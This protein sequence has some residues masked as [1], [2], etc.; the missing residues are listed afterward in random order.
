M[1]GNMQLNN[2]SSLRLIRACRNIPVQPA[3]AIMLHSATLQY[4]LRKCRCSPPPNAEVSIPAL[5]LKMNCQ[6]SGPR[7]MELA[8]EHLL[9]RCTASAP[10][11]T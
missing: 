3:A 2:P 4:L 8:T 10:E 11:W 1:S 7:F 5:H 9:G 6:P